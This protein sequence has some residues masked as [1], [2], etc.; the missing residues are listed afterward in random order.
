LAMSELE[1]IKKADYDQQVLRKVLA[2]KAI[3]E[4]TGR[5]TVGRLKRSLAELEIA[6][7]QFESV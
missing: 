4:N 3:D 2:R 7:E 5:Q 1:E 6:L